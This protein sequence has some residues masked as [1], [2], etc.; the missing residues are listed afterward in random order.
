MSGEEYHHF[1]L[2][3]ELWE[4]T[5][6]T[7]GWGPPPN[8]A[9]KELEGLPFSGVGK[10]EKLGRF[11]DI[12]T[13]PPP[14]ASAA[15]KKRGK[16]PAVVPTQKDE[17]KD[18]TIVESKVI[19]KGKKKGIIGARRQQNVPQYIGAHAI[20]SITRQ[21]TPRLESQ[22]K[23]DIPITIKPRMCRGCRGSHRS[24]WGRSGS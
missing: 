8:F 22:H 21:S 19:A 18:F 4:S 10:T 15:T 16:E 9:S 20:D 13:A 14:I 5:S 24:T 17:D 2:T 6:N 11:F 3:M 7:T 23:Q 1:T 12:F